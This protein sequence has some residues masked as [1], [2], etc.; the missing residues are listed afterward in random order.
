[1]AC[2]LGVD[3]LR[4]MNRKVRVDYTY[5]AGKGLKTSVSGRMILK[6]KCKLQTYEKLCQCFLGWFSIFF[7]Q[8]STN[9]FLPLKKDNPSQGQ[10]N[11]SD[12]SWKSFLLA[13]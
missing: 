9:V 11:R 8:I 1:M 10:W 7:M 4:P 5:D 12:W 3:H 6:Y 2:K 13:N